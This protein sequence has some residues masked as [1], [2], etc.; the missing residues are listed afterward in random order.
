MKDLPKTPSELLAVALTDVQQLNRDIYY[1]D[2]RFFH[3]RTV[4]PILEQLNRPQP[5][6]YICRICLAGAAMVGSL[7]ARYDL[8]LTPAE[9]SMVAEQLYALDFMRQDDWESAFDCLGVP[10]AMIPAMR[11]VECK[12]F[13]G[14]EE[15]DR[16]A[17]S[18]W[19][20]VRIL[21]EAGL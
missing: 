13:S 11:R 5:P 1:P 14:W 10:A 15:F 3:K 21:R 19:A 17:E 12:Y 7:D 20:N 2:A 4:N 16:H 8:E 6:A 18:Q 9:F